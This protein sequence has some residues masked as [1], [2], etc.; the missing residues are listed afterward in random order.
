MVA[1][2]VD[3]KAEMLVVLMDWMSVDA[4]AGLMAAW[5]VL[6]LVVDLVAMWAAMVARLVGA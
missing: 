6:L 5:T 1:W 3:W 4:W 2:S